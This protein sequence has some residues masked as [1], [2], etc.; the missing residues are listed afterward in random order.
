[1]PTSVFGLNRPGMNPRT[2]P[3]EINFHTETDLILGIYRL[4][5]EQL[6]V[7]SSGAWASALVRPK[8]FNS[9]DCGLENLPLNTRGFT[10]VPK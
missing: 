8:G 4:K 9:A 6:T 10:R 2:T 3:P 1:M 7:A 5:G